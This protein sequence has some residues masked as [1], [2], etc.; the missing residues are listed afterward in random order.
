MHIV[1]SCR[2][3]RT[4]TQQYHSPR[5]TYKPWL[6][7]QSLTYLGRIK[8]LLL[9]NKRPVSYFA[10][11]CHFSQKKKEIQSIVNASLKKR[12]RKDQNPYA[13]IQNP[14][15]KSNFTCPADTLKLALGHMFSVL[16]TLYI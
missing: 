9:E 13:K 10:P 15:T 1:H 11:G 6:P 12:Q 3:R 8:Y 14:S 16:E 4:A 7:E 5:V 2:P